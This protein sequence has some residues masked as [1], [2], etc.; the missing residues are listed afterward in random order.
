VIVVS[1]LRSGEEAAY[2]AYALRRP[3]SLFYVSTRYR[4]LLCELLGCQDATLVARGA[5][6]EIRGVLPVLW[7]D[8]PLGRVVN[9]LPYYG[10]N[11]GV[12]ASD[13]EAATALAAAWNG[14]AA[15]TGALAATIVANPFA[16]DVHPDVTSNLH[17]ERIAQWTCL[18]DGD[19]LERV[20]GSAR[21]NARKAQSAGIV[22]ERDPSAF[23]RLYEIHEANISALGGM[24]KGRRFFELVRELL[25][26]DDDYDL[27]VARLDGVVVAA[28]LAFPFNRTVEYFTPAVE[29]DARPL[30]PLAA[31]LHEALPHYADCGFSVWN[32][33]GTW[34]SQESVHR[35]KRKWG[36]EDRIYPYFVQLNDETLLDHS[37]S[38]ILNAY[39]GFY[40][41]PFSA[42]RNQGGVSWDARS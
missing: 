19:P 4:G 37:Q 9:S 18:D 27:W 32:W 25:R 35:F 1:T 15:E 3:E 17:D 5:D 20:E 39:R 16:P 2:D 26:S 6:G 36:A 11:G 28:L 34:H 42:L 24:P 7:M 31:I 40:V 38:E 30:Q 22:V 21:R 29:H 33:G 41:V 10:S 23:G 13:D 12:L 8:G 14:L